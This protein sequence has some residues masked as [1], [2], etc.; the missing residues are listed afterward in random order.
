[1][2]PGRRAILTTVRPESRR[3]DVYTLVRTQLDEGRQ[4]YVVYPLIEESEKV[5]LKA[6]TEMA[7]HAARTYFRR[8]AWRCFTAG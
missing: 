5:D 8:T 6:A 1:M 4:A 7:D 2:P 3:D